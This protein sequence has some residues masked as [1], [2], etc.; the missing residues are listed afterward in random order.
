MNVCRLC[1][2]EKSSL[3]FNV[4]LSDQTTSNWSYRELIEHHTRVSLRTSKLLPQSICE[5]CRV[6]V[7][8]FAEFSHKVEAAQDTF[9]IEDE[10]DEDLLAKK[11]FK[12][13]HP[14]ELIPETIIKEQLR[15]ESESESS[16]GED[17][18]Q[19]CER[20]KVIAELYS[21]KNPH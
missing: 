8:R 4:E 19:T 17:E 6:L 18:E 2:E 16:S 11:C 14:V 5:E 9:T 15:F 1:G 13:L 12:E 21:T 20:S 7:D 10:L 3:D